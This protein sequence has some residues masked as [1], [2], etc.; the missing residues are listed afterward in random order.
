V[1]NIAVPAHLDGD[2]DD[3]VAEKKVAQPIG[4]GEIGIH[5]EPVYYIETETVSRVI[6][7]STLERRG[8]LAE[9]MHVIGDHVHAHDE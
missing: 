3:S 9:E 8:G 1:N 5:A 4:G 7:V 2:G 6:R